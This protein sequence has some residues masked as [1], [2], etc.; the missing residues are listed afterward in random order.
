MARIGSKLYAFPPD[1]IAIVLVVQRQVFVICAAPQRFHS[2]QC[3]QN[4]R[5]TNVMTPK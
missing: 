2:S 1:K 4:I 3:K 5:H